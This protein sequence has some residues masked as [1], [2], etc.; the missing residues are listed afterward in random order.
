MDRKFLGIVMT[1]AEVQW[2]GLEPVMD[3]IAATG[4]QAIC[5]G[6]SLSQPAQ[7][8]QGH[9]EPPLDIDGYERLLDRPL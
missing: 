9:R 4:A 8:G 1:P 2:E 6:V 5:T 7:S 3:T